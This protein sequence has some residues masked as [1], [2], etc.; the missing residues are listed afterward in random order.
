MLT[1]SMLKKEFELS[2][3]QQKIGQE[4]SI[5]THVLLKGQHAHATLCTMSSAD[6]LVGGGGEEGSDQYRTC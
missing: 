3:L 2:K 1:L 6:H 5:C 4:V